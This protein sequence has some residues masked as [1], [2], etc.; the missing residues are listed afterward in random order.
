[1]LVVKD[2]L[3]KVGPEFEARVMTSVSINSSDLFMLTRGVK[4]TKRCRE[5][6]PHSTVYGLQQGRYCNI[7]VY[8]HGEA[9]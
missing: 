6:L 3:L 8:E 9:P 2:C 4:Y 5:E 1:M 7:H